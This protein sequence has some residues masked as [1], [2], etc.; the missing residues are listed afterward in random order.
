[1]NYNEEKFV[2]RLIFCE[3][4]GFEKNDKQVGEDDDSDCYLYTIMSS[5][6]DAYEPGG[7][8]LY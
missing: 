3:K 2:Q 6:E 8:D 7:N 4:V 5:D 1:M